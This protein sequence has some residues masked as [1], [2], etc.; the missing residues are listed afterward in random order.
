MEREM[1]SLAAPLLFLACAS[2]L[3][4]QVAGYPDFEIVESAPVESGLDNPDVRNAH[5]VWLEMINGARNTFDCEEFYVSA[6]KG[7]PLD[8]VIE[9]M[10]GA[11]GRGV[12]VRIIGDSRMHKTYPDP[13]DMLGKVKNIT[14]RIIDFGKL[15][16]GVQH[17]KYFIVDGEQIFLGSQNFDW[18]SLK[19][20]HELG[21]RISHPGAVAVYQ[22]IF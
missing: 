8:E 16:G 7:E 5:E 19:H 21:V 1:K 13:L 15:A 12:A 3:F 20:I 10:K 22:T 17:A 6:E 9:A 2:P 18:R 14:V 4:S 11:A